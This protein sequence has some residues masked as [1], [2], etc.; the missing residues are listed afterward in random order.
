[1]SPSSGVILLVAAPA[2][3]PGAVAGAAQAMLLKSATNKSAAI[4]L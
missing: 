4:L 3:N 2:R 1:L